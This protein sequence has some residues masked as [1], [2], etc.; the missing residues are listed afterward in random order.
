MKLLGVVILSGV[1]LASAYGASYTQHEHRR[2]FSQWQDLIEER[3]TLNLQ[4][5]QLQ[6]E[7][8]ALS[9]HNLVEQKVTEGLDMRMPKMDEIIFVAAVEPDE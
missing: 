8:G 3:D 7:R 1:V 2:Y 9:T 6:L 5:G 4:W